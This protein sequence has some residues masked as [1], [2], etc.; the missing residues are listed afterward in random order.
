MPLSEK[1]I[2]K[3]AQCLRKIMT[4]QI[5][6]SARYLGEMLIQSDR[7]NGLPG[8]KRNNV[9]QKEKKRIRIH[10]AFTSE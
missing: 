7:V 5:M 9:I 6:I 4:G 8:N 2:Q 10:Y 1:E 3:G